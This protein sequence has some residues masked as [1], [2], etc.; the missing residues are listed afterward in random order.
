MKSARSLP[1]WAG[2]VQAY[3]IAAWADA[4]S[5]WCLI[6][7]AVCLWVTVAL[8]EPRFLVLVPVP[9]AGLWWRRTHLVTDPV[10]ED[11]L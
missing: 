1:E 2:Q 5:R 10:H 9:A 6:G 7:G 3:L 11:W 8:T 4:V